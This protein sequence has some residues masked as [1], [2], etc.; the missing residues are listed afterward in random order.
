MQEADFLPCERH[1]L[2][3]LGERVERVGGVFYAQPREEQQKWFFC[4]GL[5][6]EEVVAL[7]C[8]DSRP[9]KGEVIARGKT[10]FCS[11]PH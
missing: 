6:N 1:Y 11:M 4:D 8:F 10:L 2:D 9:D 3:A 5:T 7:K